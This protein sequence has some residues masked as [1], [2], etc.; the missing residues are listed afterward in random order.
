M[1]LWKYTYIT[2]IYL[3]IKEQNEYESY[4]YIFIDMKLARTRWITATR[5]KSDW[6]KNQPVRKSKE[7]KHHYT[8]QKYGHGCP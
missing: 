1:C 4:M 8:G 5:E 3:K 6:S 2:N 7:Q